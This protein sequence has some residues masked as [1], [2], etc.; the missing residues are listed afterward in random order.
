MTTKA[1]AIAAHHTALN[2]ITAATTT[3]ELAAAL[4]T[5]KHESTGLKFEGPDGTYWDAKAGFFVTYLD[6]QFAMTQVHQ[7]LPAATMTLWG[8]LE[9]ERRAVAEQQ[10]AAAELAA[11]D[12]DAA[13]RG[14]P[15][16]GDVVQIRL[17][18]WLLKLVDAEASAEGLKR[19]E[20]IRRL[21]VEA[22]TARRSPAAPATPPAAVAGRRW[23]DA[24]TG[25]EELLE[26]ED[27]TLV[28]LL[29]GATAV[30][31]QREGIG[32]HRAA[33]E[34]RVGPLTLDLR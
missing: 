20:Y 33:V 13:R 8:Q 18:K 24:A 25:F 27:G 16:I 29:D 26:L 5:I 3:A 32:E 10:N 21:I 11:D 12:Q 7:A 6:G 28:D 30:Q 4:D 23:T 19:S 34:R 22:R 17:P 2:R 15:S 1:D 14:R 9:D 31:M